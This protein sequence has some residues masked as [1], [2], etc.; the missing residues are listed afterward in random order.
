MRKAVLNVSSTEDNP[1]VGAIIT[2]EDIYVSP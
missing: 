1:P 2:M